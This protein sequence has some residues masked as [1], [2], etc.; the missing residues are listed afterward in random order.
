MILLEANWDNALMA[1]FGLLATI[2]ACV[3]L[4]AIVM[5]RHKKW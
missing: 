1:W 3:G 2:V 5:I 4:W